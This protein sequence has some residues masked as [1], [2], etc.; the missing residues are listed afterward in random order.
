MDYSEKY[1]K[2]VDE[3]V[4]LAIKDLGISKDEAAVEILEAPTKGF[5]GIG[6]KLAKVRVSVCSRADKIADEFL[7]SVFEKMGI[8]IKYRCEAIDDTVVVS[9]EG[10]DSGIVI[11]KRGHTLDSLQY[12]T[13]LVVNKNKDKYT[14][15]IINAESYRQK[16]EKT[17]IDLANRLAGKVSSNGRSI[18][19]EP[20]NPYERRIIHSALQENNRVTTK[21]EGEDPY[22]RVVIDKK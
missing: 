21:S 1:G 8:S 4:E 12:L 20:M 15:I 7:G 17:L 5:L 11:G 2:T 18:R 13:S 16:R 10:K 22:R 3:A 6:A 14:R 19:L 9:I